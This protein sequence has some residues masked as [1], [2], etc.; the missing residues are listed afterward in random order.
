MYATLEKY[1]IILVLFIDISQ[2]LELNLPVAIIPSPGG[3]R[4]WDGKF[5]GSLPSSLILSVEL[6]KKQ[7]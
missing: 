1:F 6:V 2:H 5:S 7:L 4:I 3:A